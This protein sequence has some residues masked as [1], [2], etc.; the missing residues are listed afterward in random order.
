[1]K[2][3]NTPGAPSGAPDSDPGSSGSPALIRRPDERYP[4][5]SDY[6]FLSDCHSVALVSRTGSIDWA[7]MP[8][9]DAPSI[10][11]R[12]LDWDKAGFCAITPD[13]AQ[14]VTERRY[15]EH[16]MVLETRMR[17]ANGDEVCLTDAIAMRSG[18][19]RSPRNQILRRV[20]C[21]R[22]EV[23]LNVRIEA[24]FDMGWAKPWIRAY[25]DHVFTL[26]GG[27]GGL[28]V[29]TD[30]DLAPDE[31][32]DLH[33]RTV[34]RAGETRRLSLTFEP[35]ELLDEG[36]DA[37]C[38]PEAVDD[39]L[40]E[41]IEWWRQWAERGER[42]GE[43]TEPIARSALVLK[44]LQTAMTGAIA[45]AATTSL[46]EALG[47]GRNWD[48]RYSW[49]RDSWLTVR[50]LARVGHPR[51][52]YGF[53]R[54]VERSAAGSVDELQLMY[55]VDGAHRTPEIELPEL[56]GY[57]DSR[58]VRIGNYAATQLQLDMFGSLLELEWLWCQ[59]GEMPRDS[60][61]SFMCEVVERAIDCWHQPDAGIWEVRDAPRHF[62][63]SKVMC[64]V[65][66][67]CGLLVA[68]CAGR[69]VDVERWT[70]VRDRI[71]DEIFEK[72]VSPKRGCFVAS[73]GSEDM[74]ASLLL[75]PLVGFIEAD[76]PR[77]RATVDAVIADLDEGGLILRYR[78]P[79]GLE[80]EEGTF[81]AC[82]FWLVE[83]LAAQGRLD[84]ARA[85]FD[86]ASSVANDLGLFTEEYD[87][88]HDVALGNFP[89][90]LSHLAHIGAALALEDC[91]GR[92]GRV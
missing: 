4:S 23:P 26:V 37:P 56:A 68:E 72:G 38:P 21:V 12:I 3:D 67:H 8:R 17:T 66:V 87:T 55:G 30:F 75:L 90:G 7:C 57:R 10:F 42:H 32:H 1:L 20:T 29:S 88:R 78:T 24:R 73:Y 34:L 60:Y 14:I 48:Y 9:I 58:P 6:G 11:G 62:V 50:S 22:G 70:R 15:L 82:A 51:E 74:D 44:A 45:A 16:T 91:A 81:L 76:D 79:D 85:Y 43:L 28:V 31:R 35:P 33:G 2:P 61:W 77:M 84:E 25:G 71:R 80:G 27:H 59:R 52:A 86:R 5:I 49:I 13:A 39:R 19:S 18:G 69:E 40:D 89:Q 36:P 41:T 63:H 53:R 47:Y 46:P 83:C 64:W 54:F 65:A 92:A